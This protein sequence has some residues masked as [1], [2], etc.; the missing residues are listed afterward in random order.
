VG[1][2]RGALGCG[3]EI[4][5]GEARYRMRVVSLMACTYDPMHLP[6]LSLTISRDPRFGSGTKAWLGFGAG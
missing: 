6:R 1:L 2:E 3:A 4:G 5:D